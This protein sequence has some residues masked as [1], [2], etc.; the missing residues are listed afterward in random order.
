[1]N[2]FELKIIVLNR[3]SSMIKKKIY[4]EKETVMVKLE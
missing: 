2:D 3:C 4:Q 1:M